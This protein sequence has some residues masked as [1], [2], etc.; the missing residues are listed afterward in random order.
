MYR[1]IAEI[2]RG[3]HHEALYWAEREQKNADEIAAQINAEKAQKTTQPDV[4]GRR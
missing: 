4:K 1:E 2:D 3:H